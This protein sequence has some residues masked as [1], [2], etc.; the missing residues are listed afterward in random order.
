P[1]ARPPGFDE[2]LRG[3]EQGAQKTF[4]IRYPDDY[5]IAELAGKTVN[6]DVSV[7][8]LRK[9]IV[10]VLDDEFAKDLGEF[11]SLEALRGRVREDLEH[12]AKHEAERELRAELM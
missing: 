5:T 7:K 4:D 8:A 2:Q 9:R 6:Y 12:E 11:A 1:T 10:P 3:L